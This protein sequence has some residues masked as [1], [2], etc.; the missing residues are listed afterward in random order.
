M[1]LNWKEIDLILNE[2]NLPGAQIQKVTQSSYDTLCLS[3][4]GHAGLQSLLIVITPGVCRLHNTHRAVPKTEKPLRF[5]ELLKS[6]ILNFR[7]EEAVQIGSDRIIRFALRHG[8]ERLFLFSKLWSNAANVLLCDKDG[9]IIDAMRR[10]PKRGEIKGGIIDITNGKV[11]VPELKTGAPLS[12]SSNKIT[13]AAQSSAT[14]A[15]ATPAPTP[16]AHAAHTPTPAARTT[17]EVRNLPGSGSFNSRVDDWYAVHGQALSLESLRLRAQKRFGASISRLEAALER[18]YAKEADFSSPQRLKEYGEI[19]LANVHSIKKGDTWLNAE[20]FYHENTAIRVK[21]DPQKK[22]QENAAVYFEQYQK[23]KNGL[24]AVRAEIDAV[25]SEILRQKTAF[26]ALLLEENPLRLQK[27][28]KTN[29][30]GDVK[31]EKTKTGLSFKRGNWLIFV[32]RSAAENDELLRRHVKGND[33]WLHARD[34][35]GAYVFI[36]ARS[37][38]SVPLEILLDAGNLA[39]FY[40]KGRNGGKG[41]LFYTQVKYLR[42]AKGKPRGQ[43]LPTQEKNIFIKLEERRLKE[44]E[45]CKVQSG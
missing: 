44:L 4:Y 36:K 35:P 5:S 13:G 38:K 26:D 18:L 20:D 15:S 16:A 21:L 22:A 37:G 32:G 24:E 30:G 33:L 43:V 9:V 7:I 8:S 28:L 10:L 34:F 40:S 41:D 6:R 3:L 2:L 12:A 25:R 31:N 1:S 45:L 27:I 23:A 14:P 19:I 11:F 42:R 17:Y 29:S 39:L